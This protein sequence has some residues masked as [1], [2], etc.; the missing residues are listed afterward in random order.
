MEEQSDTE[1]ALPIPSGFSWVQRD[2]V[3]LLGVFQGRR[4]SSC[5]VYAS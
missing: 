4:K 1:S 5:G 3:R 2:V